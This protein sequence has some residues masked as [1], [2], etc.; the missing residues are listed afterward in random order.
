MTTQFAVA[1][2]DGN[3]QDCYPS[4]TAWRGVAAMRI[5]VCN[6]STDEDDVD[7][8]VQAILAAHRAC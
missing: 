4:A 7:R 3:G 1:A 2:H 6:W 8:S 5:S